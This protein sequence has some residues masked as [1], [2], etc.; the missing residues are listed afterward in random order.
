MKALSM[1]QPVPEL[2][3]QGKKTIE[4][5]KWK[6]SFRGKFLLHASLS[7]LKGFDIDPKDL[8]HGFLVGTA[9]LVE[10]IKFKSKE[11]FESL[12]NKHLA[13]SETWFIPK[14][15]Y[16]FI[17]ENPERLEKPIPYKGQ[18][19]FF[20]VNIQDKRQKLLSEVSI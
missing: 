6:T 4:L 3:L 14:R 7:E 20:D 10:V 8:P 17:L 11:Q 2:I 12:K 13:K 1:K 15:T 19:N 9:D 5:R 18:L 16:G